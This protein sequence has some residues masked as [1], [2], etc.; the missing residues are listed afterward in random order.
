[1][2]KS[3]K[4]G[5]NDWHSILQSEKWSSLLGLLHEGEVWLEQEG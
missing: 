2:L 3:Q 1:M 4:Q 5:K